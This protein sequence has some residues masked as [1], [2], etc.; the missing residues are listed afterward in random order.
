MFC[1]KKK[2]RK[3]A[4]RY[5]T[6]L[7]C[8]FIFFF[9]LSAWSPT[10][11]NQTRNIQWTINCALSGYFIIRSCI[12]TGGGGCC[13]CCCSLELTW[14][15]WQFDAIKSVNHPIA[16]AKQQQRNMYSYFFFPHFDTRFSELWFLSSEIGRLLCKLS[17]YSELILLFQFCCFNFVVCIKQTRLSV[18]SQFYLDLYGFF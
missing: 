7:L 2:K 1:F 8:L 5:P 12:S 17:D 15:T 14:L 10:G 13:C 11:F 4:F 9:L 16:V 6:W 18:I 3:K